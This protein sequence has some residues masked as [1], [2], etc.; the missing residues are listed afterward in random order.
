MRAM[1]GMLPVIHIAPGGYSPRIY[2]RPPAQA[3]H[4]T[5]H[6]IDDPADQ[7]QLTWIY[8]LE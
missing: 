8:R 3:L 1:Q 4:C 6:A 7:D 2:H 5:F